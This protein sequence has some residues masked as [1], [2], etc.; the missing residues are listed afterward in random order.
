MER[1]TWP[2]SE[3]TKGNISYIRTLKIILPEQIQRTNWD[4][5]SNGPAVIGKTKINTLNEKQRST[6]GETLQQ[7]LKKECNFKLNYRNK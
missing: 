1:P 6:F 7:I 3:D 4:K 2:T 5:K